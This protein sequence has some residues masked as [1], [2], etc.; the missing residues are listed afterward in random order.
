L[1]AHQLN[2]DSTGAE[3]GHMSTRRSLIVGTHSECNASYAVSPAR[4]QEVSRAQV[5]ATR[6]AGLLSSGG[7]ANDQQ[8]HPLDGDLRT[9]VH[10]QLAAFLTT[11]RDAA[12]QID[13]QFV[14]AVDS[15]SD[16]VLDGG[17]RLRPTFT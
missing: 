15:L 12:T 10:R 7:P 16:F 4:F 13:P 6:G 3:P 1:K 8:A 2:R 14:A 11:K 5:N 9:E 17:K